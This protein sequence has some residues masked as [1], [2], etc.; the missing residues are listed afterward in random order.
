[1]K[2]GKC[3][4]SWVLVDRDGYVVTGHRSREA[5]EA[6]RTHH[7]EAPKAQRAKRTR[8]FPEPAPQHPSYYAGSTHAEEVAKHERYLKELNE[9]EK[10]KSAWEAGKK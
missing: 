2:L 9:W 7:L 4:K 3:G 6:A 5:A 1:M 10:R 8:R